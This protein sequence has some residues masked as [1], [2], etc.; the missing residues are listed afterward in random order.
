MIAERDLRE[1]D[2]VFA[3][4]FRPELDDAKQMILEC[5][6]RGVPRQPAFPRVADRVLHQL[7]RVV[8]VDLAACVRNAECAWAGEPLNALAQLLRELRLERVDPLLGAMTLVG[9]AI[10][11]IAS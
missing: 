10:S 9:L 8:V 3:M 4:I 11:M 6:L 7:A 5:H 1:I 2:L